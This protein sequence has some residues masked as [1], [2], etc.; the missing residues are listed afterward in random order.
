LYLM[1]PNNQIG[2]VLTDGMFLIAHL[3]KLLKRGRINLDSF[4]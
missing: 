4:E 3:Q 1:N 2:N